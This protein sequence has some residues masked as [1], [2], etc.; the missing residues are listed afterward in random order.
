MFFDVL[1]HLGTLA[2]VFVAYRKEIGAI[3][4]DTFALLRKSPDAYYVDSN[5][6]KR[7]SPHVRELLFIIIATLPLFV[8]VPFFDVLE[9]LY[10]STI[11][12]GIA[13]LVTGA[14][15]YISDRLPKGRKNEKSMTVLDVLLIGVGQGIATMP[16]ISR[17]GTTISVGLARGFKRDFAVRFAFLLS[18]PAVIGSNILSLIKAVKAGIDWSLLPVYLAGVVTAAVVGYLCIFL[19]KLIVSKS[20][21]GFFAY[22]CWIVGALTLILSFVLK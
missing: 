1:L 11:F 5:G 9:G 19:V 21:F 18:I 12:I 3:I 6:V 14:V 10:S 8:L 13:L 20:K 4:K 7:V 15:L 22:Y 16:G 17:S 2:A